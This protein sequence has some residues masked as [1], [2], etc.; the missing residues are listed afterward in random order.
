M[1]SQLSR[2]AL[3]HS[4]FTV[5]LQVKAI[6]SIEINAEKSFSPDK[7]I[8]VKVIDNTGKLQNGSQMNII[9]REDGF[10]M[11]YNRSEADKILVNLPL[12][13]LLMNFG[14]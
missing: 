8:K 14:S 3:R 4:S 10:Y 2:L 1:A 13:P 12:S 9:Q 6:E 11:N 7:R 5:K